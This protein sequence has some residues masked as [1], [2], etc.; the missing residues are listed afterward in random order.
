MDSDPDPEQTGSSGAS[1]PP[2]SGE[3]EGQTCSR[4]G[5]CPGETAF[6][7]FLGGTLPARAAKRMHEHLRIC[8]PCRR[9]VDEMRDIMAVEPL[10]MPES[11][12][13]RFV[14]VVAA[15]LSRS[16]ES[17]KRSRPEST[18]RER[19]ARG[20]R[21]LFP[22]FA[23][24]SLLC[25]GLLF[26]SVVAG[27]FVFRAYLPSM[28]S[29]NSGDSRQVDVR[30]QP[31]FRE[32]CVRYDEAISKVRKCVLPV[33]VE[34][35]RDL[36]S[37]DGGYRA[38][39]EKPDWGQC[40]DTWSRIARDLSDAE[41]LVRAGRYKTA[42]REYSAVGKAMAEHQDIASEGGEAAACKGRREFLR[43][44]YLPACE[45]RCSLGL[46]DIAGAKER[47]TQTKR[48]LPGGESASRGCRCGEFCPCEACRCLEQEVTK[49]LKYCEGYGSGM[50]A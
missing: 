42:L 22:R 10:E 44:V 38:T 4:G 11:A 14:R 12:R 25:G 1:R 26:A 3:R 37:G 50:D 5:E 15:A 23:T 20:W 19:S 17:E 47:L 21:F 45:A 32:L 36:A 48:F 43:D 16:Q 30:S 46:G 24:A 18:R 8:E 7:S 39:G 6:V 34:R 29:G 31:G 35:S 40:Q 41:A 2:N 49:A 33:D 13:E 27:I 9:T 28:S